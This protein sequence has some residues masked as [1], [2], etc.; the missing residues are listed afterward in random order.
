MNPWNIC[1]Y[2]EKIGKG[3]AEGSWKYQETQEIYTYTDDTAMAR[4]VADSI[5]SMRSV[6][7]KSMSKMFV[8]EYFKN[9]NRG[10]GG[11]VVDV[12]KKLRKSECQ[13]P[14]KPATEQFNGSG[15]YGNGNAVLSWL[16]TSAF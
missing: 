15:S 7:P 9:P 6:D 14:F 8:E 10:Y 13:E 5:I 16:N 4:S 2:G 1:E 3:V 12:F 11:S